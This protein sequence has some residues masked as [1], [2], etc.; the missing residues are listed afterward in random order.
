MAGTTLWR[1]LQF[2]TPLLVLAALWQ[3]LSAAGVLD[4]FIF[5][6]PSRIAATMARLA[7]GPELWTHV[8]Y[9]SVRAAI[10]FAGAVLIGLPLG[11]LMGISRTFERLVR[12][13]VSLLLHIST[14][15]LIPLLILLMGIGDQTA[16]S[17]AFLSGFT[18][19]TYNAYNG[20]Q[21]IPRSYVWVMKGLEGSRWQLFTHVWLPGSLR[22]VLTGS[23]IG[24][25]RA[26]RALVA[27]EMLAATT[28]GIGVMIMDAREYMQTDVVYAGIIVLAV[29]GFTIENGLIG[30]LEKRTIDR[31]GN[32]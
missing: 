15:A 21:A 31:W 5:P 32:E 28:K 19:I 24:L 23:R 11:I 2:I 12:P 30:Q 3:L 7:A 13:F 16:A 14:I 1:A 17:I 9:T 8:A 10:G 6:P 27:A 4:D 18:A 20:V 29:L 25:A 22:H 26:W